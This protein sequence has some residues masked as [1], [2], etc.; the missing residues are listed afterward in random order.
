MFLF[1]SQNHI[2]GDGFIV[3][4]K[5]VDG[6]WFSP[7]E[8]LE[9]LL[10]QT[11]YQFI[12]GGEA[13]AMVVYRVSAYLAGALF[14][15]GVFY[16]APK[17]HRLFA[18]VVGL[19]FGTMQFFFG[20]VEN[21]TYSFLFGFFYLA[22]AVRD[23]EKG[24]LSRLTMVWFLVGVGFHF[25]NL[26][27]L[28][29]FL[30]HLLQFGRRRQRAAP[31]M[32]VTA[33][34]SIGFVLILGTHVTLSRILVPPV[35]TAESAY[36][37]FS[38]Q[39]LSNIAN[40]LLLGSPLIVVIPFAVAR[41]RTR[42]FRFLLIA[43]A[44]ALLFVVLMNPWLG[45]YRD[46]DLF[47]V[48]AAPVL[49]WLFQML[50]S[51]TASSKGAP[52]R[53]LIPILILALLK[54]GSWVWGNTR[55]IEAY[56]Y[57]REVIR[58]DLHYATSCIQGA[59]NKPWGVLAAKYYGDDAEALRAWAVRFAGDPGDAGNVRSLVRA[60]GR[61]GDTAAANDLVAQHWTRFQHDCQ[62]LVVMAE[63]MVVVG[64]LTL[65]E[66]LYERAVVLNGSDDRVRQNLMIIKGRLR[67]QQ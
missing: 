6:L 23:L 7:L 8:P 10:H 25:R 33:L 67:Q 65:A 5:V 32:I 66:Q 22:S 16:F 54:T 13:G 46:W 64:N 26:F 61:V 40:W 24:K 31:I 56:E 48:A 57:A 62:T 29:A 60:H 18:L 21:Y 2:L 44:G 38:F 1:P 14:L 51:E 27:L 58:K 41:Y 12:G 34:L 45:A 43:T 17:R 36:T 37:F 53:L 3:A 42:E 59:R 11:L 52:Y 35:V 47:S 39:H 50:K 63:V 15:A 9:Y 20:Y 4:N 55:K 28:P 19:T 49:V 30:Y